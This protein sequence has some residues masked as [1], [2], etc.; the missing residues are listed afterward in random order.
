MC[1]K[2][3]RRQHCHLDCL[4]GGLLALKLVKGSPPGITAILT[5]LSSSEKTDHALCD[6][7]YVKNT[8]KK[9]SRHPLVP[10]QNSFEIETRT[11]MIV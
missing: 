6:A 5:L 8:E 7:I 2:I 10:D 3:I 9:L 1:E 4:G 11:S